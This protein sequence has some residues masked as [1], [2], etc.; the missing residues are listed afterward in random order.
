MAGS[1]L[2]TSRPCGVEDCSTAVGK[3]GA[4]GMCVKHYE[5]WK[6]HGDVTAVAWARGDANASTRRVAELHPLW[7]GDTPTYNGAHLRVRRSR[8][9][10]SRNPCARCGCPARDWAYDHEDPNELSGPTQH[11]YEMSYSGNPDHYIPL[12]RPCHTA[13]DRQPVIVGEVR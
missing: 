9:A 13:F 12:C 6:K 1:R 4:R 10:A 11:G 3:S 7:T 2:P 8:G 5:R